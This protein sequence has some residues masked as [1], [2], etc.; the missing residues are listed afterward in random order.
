MSNAVATPKEIRKQLRTISSE[1]FIKA[2]TL[3]ALTVVAVTLKIEVPDEAK[4]KQQVYD[5]IVAG[6]NL[7]DPKLRGKSTKESPVAFVWN[8][9]DK[10][11]AAQKKDEDRAKRSEVVVACQ[12]QGIAY[13]TARTQFQ[14][15]FTT[16]DKGR[17][18][19][20]DLSLEELPKALHPVKEAV[21]S[22]G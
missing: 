5:A 6:A 18:R 20:S 19:L 21:A 11:V 12:E 2:H 15:W 14:A 10:M 9:A 7:P 1:E 17:R 13:Y 22:D 8:I 3:A 4:T 16:T